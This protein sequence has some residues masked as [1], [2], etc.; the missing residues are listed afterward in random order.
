VTAL[1]I[2]I[3]LTDNDTE[4]RPTEDTQ[5]NKRRFLQ[6]AAALALA[7]PAWRAWAAAPDAAAVV[8]HYAALVRAN[9]EDSLA[10]AQELQAA[11]KALAAAPGEQTLAGARSAWIAAR[12]WY[13]Q[14]EAFRFYGGP[15]DDDKGP[16]GRINAWPMDEAY[17]DAV[18]GKPGAGIINNRKA[19]LTKAALSRANERG[20][21]ENVSCG[22]HAIEFLLWGRT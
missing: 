15:I 10:G 3:I 13:G 1:L 2:R 22:W 7:G 21:E 5:V 11:V 19:A 20:G 16:E 18:A 9:Y 17:V 4:T 6:S 12:E 8:L 14:T